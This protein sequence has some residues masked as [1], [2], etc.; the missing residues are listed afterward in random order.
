MLPYPPTDWYEWK[1]QFFSYFCSGTFSK[2][3]VR[4]KSGIIS[5]I[6]RTDFFKSFSSSIPV[7]YCRWQPSTAATFQKPAENVFQIRANQLSRTDSLCLR[8]QPA[9]SQQKGQSAAKNNHGQ[10]IVK[11]SKNKDGVLSRLWKVQ[12]GTSILKDLAFCY[13]CVTSVEF[14]QDIADFLLFTYNSWL[15]SANSFMLNTWIFIHLE[16]HSRPRPCP[17]PTKQK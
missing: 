17:R 15:S 6:A 13:A 10:R 1:T 16:L 3:C 12:Q 14:E 4:N 5:R 11:V 7:D 2:N 8:Q 9:N